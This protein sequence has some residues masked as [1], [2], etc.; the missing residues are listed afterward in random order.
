MYT[1]GI[2]HGIQLVVRGLDVGYHLAHQQLNLDRV[3]HREVHEWSRLQLEFDRVVCA[4]ACI[5]DPIYCL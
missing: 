3:L 1:D 4:Q 2:D 5:E